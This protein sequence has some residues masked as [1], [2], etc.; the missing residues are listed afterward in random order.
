MAYQG[1]VVKAGQQADS[2]D[3]NA[4]KEDSPAQE[5]AHCACIA[6]ISIAPLLPPLIDQNQCLRYRHLVV[7]GRR[8]NQTLARVVRDAC[9]VMLLLFIIWASIFKVRHT[10]T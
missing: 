2:V 9:C 10:G 7:M 1:Q 5:T 6:T 3:A 8:L 4:E